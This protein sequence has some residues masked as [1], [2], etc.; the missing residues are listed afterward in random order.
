MGVAALAQAQY[1]WID[2][3]GI[4]QLSDRPPPP[5]VPESRIL[6]TPRHPATAADPVPV[7]DAVPVPAP[8]SSTA[9]AAPTLAERNAE[10]QKRK[11][12]AAEQAQ[13]AADEA[14][15]KADQAVNCDNAR[16]N[17]RLLDS[18]QRIAAID[19]NG[20]RRYIGDE[21]RARQEKKTQRSLADCR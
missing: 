19:S 5:S 10:Y 17:Q 15:R 7:P 6:K 4:K 8:A 2:E 9:P 18:G 12:V 1:L 14:A 13:Q 20:E 3:K 16:Q 11:V 21:E